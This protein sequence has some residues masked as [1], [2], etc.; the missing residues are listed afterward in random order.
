VSGAEG[1][2]GVVG[3]TLRLP[4]FGHWK[5]LYRVHKASPGIK[6]VEDAY[7]GAMGWDPVSRFGTGLLFC[8]HCYTMDQQD[9]SAW[10]TLTIAR[11]K[12]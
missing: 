5:Q 4:F 2:D 11:I 8:E 6:S 12:R 7:D 3:P 1:L 10:N 9:L